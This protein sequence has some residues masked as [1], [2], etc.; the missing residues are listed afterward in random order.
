[1]AIEVKDYS[2]AKELVR[3][4]LDIVSLLEYYNLD[5]PSRGIKY[6]KVRLP[7]PLHGGDNPTGFSFDLNNKQ[8]TCFT[9]HCGEDPS[10]WWFI[11]KEKGRTVPRDVFIF[12]KLMEEKRAYEEGN[13]NFKCSFHRALKIASE[14]TG[15]SIEGMG[16]DYDKE[17]L[18]KLE[19][20]RWMR[21][22]SKVYTDIELDVF[23]EEEIELFRAMLPMA[24]SYVQTREFDYETLD[25]FEVGYSV[26]GIDEKWN[27]NKRDFCGRIVIPVRDDIGQ[28]V[29]WSGRLATD[30]KVKIKTFNKWMHKMDFDKGFVLFNYHNAKPYID[31]SREIILV[32]G[33]FDVMRLWSY[34]I[35]NAVAVMGSS[36]TPEQ[37]SLAVA[38]VLKAHVFLD[39][40]GAGLT[41]SKRI[42]EQLRNYVDV[43][44]VHGASGKD[45]DDLTFEEAWVC[46]SSPKKYIG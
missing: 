2:V 37:L 20:Q 46:V 34:G 10:D 29:G 14:V 6:D 23:S 41:G 24:E 38:R 1:M 8:F 4:K 9:H 3:E 13:R 36:L 39:D 25:F 35:R 40:D 7:C 33:P 26:E 16:V 30:D 19:N 17:T 15:I 43:Y 27:A 5:V 44:T 32:E 45:P 28:L 42:C 31:E 11:P 21:Q 22:M 18:D 12:I